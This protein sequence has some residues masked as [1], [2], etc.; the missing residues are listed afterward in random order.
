MPSRAAIHSWSASAISVLPLMP[1]DDARYSRCHP[2]I[3]SHFRY[4]HGSRATGDFGTLLGPKGP[5]ATGAPYIILHPRAISHHPLSHPGLGGSLTRTCWRAC[6]PGMLLFH[7]FD[8]SRVSCIH[9]RI[10]CPNSC[11]RSVQVLVNLTEDVAL[12]HAH[13]NFLESWLLESARLY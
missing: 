4:V 13:R 6:D 12:I 8:Y 7:L 1:G 2:T 9:P 10:S 3:M 5:S 11:R